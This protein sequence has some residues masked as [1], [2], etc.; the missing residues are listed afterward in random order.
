M[1]QKAL[2]FR[3]KSVRIKWPQFQLCLTCVGSVTLRKKYFWALLSF[4]NGNDI[5]LM[6]KNTPLLFASLRKYCYFI[7]KM[8]SNIKSM[9]ILEM[10][11]LNCKINKTS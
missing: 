6:M 7:S 4:P 1:R 11:D 8:S 9:V 3:L 5:L 10:I 2:L